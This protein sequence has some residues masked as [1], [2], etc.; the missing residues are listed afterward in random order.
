MASEK[1]KAILIRPVPDELWQYL[2][3][4]KKRITKST[5]RKVVSVEERLVNLVKCCGE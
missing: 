4:E 3:K 1:P 5:V 2:E